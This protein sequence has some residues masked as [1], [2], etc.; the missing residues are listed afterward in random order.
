MNAIELL[1]SQHREVEILFS[2]IEKATDPAEKEDLFIKLAD[3]LLIHTSIE[4]HNFYPMVRGK[5]TDDILFEALEEHL[6]IKR[7]LG[8]LL[9]LEM[10][11]SK[12]E[13]RIKLLQEE[14]EDH[15]VEEEGALFPKVR[16]MLDEGELESL[17]QAM[18]EEQ[19]E[20]ERIGPSRKA[21]PAA[22]KKLALI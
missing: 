11:D 20:L 18:S 21:T 9:D 10:E 14:V 3:R 7:V 1:T 8:E 5:R 15:V 22:I 16:S 19:A 13:A 17:G 6:G 12:F 4:E 2:E